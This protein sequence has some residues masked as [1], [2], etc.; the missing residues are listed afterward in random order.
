MSREAQQWVAALR[1]DA[2]KSLAA[3]RV[4]DKLADAHHTDSDHAYR[5]VPKLADELGCSVRTVQRAL[6]ELERLGLLIVGD[7]SVLPRSV[8]PQYAPTAYRLPWRQSWT[9]PQLP[10][11]TTTVTPADPVDN[12]ARGDRHAVPGVTTVVAHRTQEQL[13]RDTRPATVRTRASSTCAGTLEPHAFS[14]R[15]GSCVY[16]GAGRERVSA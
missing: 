13:E 5:D 6:R 7:Q 14:A 8:R 16:C 11:V 12:P 2:V 15:T 4:L 1:L 3:F 9:Q 10:G